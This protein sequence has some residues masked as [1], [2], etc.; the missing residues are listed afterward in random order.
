MLVYHRVMYMLH[1]MPFDISPRNLPEKDSLQDFPQCRSL[2]FPWNSNMESPTQCRGPS[3]FLNLGFVDP[4]KLKSYPLVIQRSE[5]DDLWWIYP[6][7]T[8]W[9]F[10]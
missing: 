9:I 7:R 1:F 8:C 10:P 6:A 4:M 5:D 3:P 2:H